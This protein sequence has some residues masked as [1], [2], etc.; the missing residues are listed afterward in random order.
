MGSDELN[1][2]DQA[3]DGH[4]QASGGWRL[5]VVYSVLTD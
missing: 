5:L 2:A 1:K 4:D 3:A